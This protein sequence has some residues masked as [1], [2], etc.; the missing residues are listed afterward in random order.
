M[1]KS[2]SHKTDNAHLDAKIELRE[3]YLPATGTV[4]VLDAYHGSG[5]IWKRIQERK[6]DRRIIVTGID[7]KPGAT[8]RGDA[9]RIVPRMALDQFDFI[10]LDAY[11]DPSVCLSAVLR[12]PFVGS[13]AVTFIQSAQGHVSNALL[14]AA[15][16][17]PSYNA[18]MPTLLSKAAWPIM[19]GVLASHG[20]SEI[21]R[22]TAHIGAS[23]VGH[24]NK[25]YFAFRLARR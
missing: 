24:V 8:I 13:C 15:G 14:V 7:L 21:T 18:S 17:D 3:A 11:G 25:N 9:T 22:Y 23:G 20:V 19:E 10:D 12:S 2:T 1:R 6:P 5:L 4:R 16:I